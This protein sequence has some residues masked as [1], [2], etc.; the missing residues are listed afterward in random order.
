[1]VILP[2]CVCIFSANVKNIALIKSKSP[3]EMGFEFDTLP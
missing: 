1:M 3:I 2:R